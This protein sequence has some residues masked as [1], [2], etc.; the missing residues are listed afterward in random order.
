MVNI[1]NLRIGS[2]QVVNIQNLMTERLQKDSI[3]K[4]PVRECRI[5]DMVAVIPGLTVMTLKEQ[6][7]ETVTLL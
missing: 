7:A 5:E 1:R 2:L 4:L 6:Y 3:R